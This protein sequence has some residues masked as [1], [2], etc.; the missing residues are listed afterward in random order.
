MGYSDLWYFSEKAGQ[1]IRKKAETAS[2]KSCKTGQP[3]R[4]DRERTD[5]GSGNS[6]K[7]GDA[8]AGGRILSCAGQT[9]TG[10]SRG[11]TLSVGKGR[12]GSGENFPGCVRC[13]KG[14][15]E[16][17]AQHCPF[18][19]KVCRRIEKICFTI[20]GICA[21][22]EKWKRFARDPHTR[23]AWNLIKGS[24]GRILHHVLPGKIKGKILFGFADPSATGQFLAAVSPFYPL[25]GKQLS[26]IP[27]FDREVLEGEIRFS[28]RIYGI[29][30]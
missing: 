18:P 20:D 23:E 22:I 28:G 26:L 25:Y 2:E 24:L 1:A 14:H 9:E 21:K 29:F 4:K 30:F 7:S 13:R 16:N 12:T 15:L 17:P 11:E 19:V 8:G 10:K 5:T 3:G 27:A 6:G